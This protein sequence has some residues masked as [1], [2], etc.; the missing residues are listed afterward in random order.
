MFG[1]EYS[2][3]SAVFNF[4]LNQI[5]NNF[6]HLVFWDNQRL[7]PQKLQ[8]YADA[9]SRKGA[10]L[11]CVV[12][13]IDGTVRKICR[14]SRNQKVAYNGHKRK[15]A[16]KYQ[17]VMAP[18]GII[19]HMFGSI[20]GARHDCFLLSESKILQKLRIELKKGGKHF[21]I[22]GDPA[23][24]YREHLV[25]PFKGARLTPKKEEFNKA[26]S[27]VQVSVKWGF[28]L[29]ARYWRTSKTPFFE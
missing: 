21:V 7:T 29:I 20:A 5:Y 3:I 9:I 15:H 1:R 12:G 16:L 17:F 10:P 19:I 8:H 6:R 4:V 18:D 22:Y 25:S 26:M 11:D 28:G 24:G 2:F 27:K 23:Y 14:L 13:F